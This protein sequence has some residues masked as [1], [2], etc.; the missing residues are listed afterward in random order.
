[1]TTYGW[2]AECHDCPITIGGYGERIKVHEKFAPNNRIDAELWAGTHHHLYGHIVTVRRFA[3]LE[4]DCTWVD[5]DALQRW[6]A[7]DTPTTEST[8]AGD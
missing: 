7:H 6:L 3:Q 5:H 4:V 2:I 8:G 1:M